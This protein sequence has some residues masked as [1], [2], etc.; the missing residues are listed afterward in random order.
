LYILKTNLPTKQSIVGGCCNRANGVVIPAV[1]CDQK[2][3]TS[4]TL[5]LNI[6][7]KIIFAIG[8]LKLNA[9]VKEANENS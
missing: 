8:R 3:A 7:I 1:I 2:K 6:K 4:C 5:H 9:H